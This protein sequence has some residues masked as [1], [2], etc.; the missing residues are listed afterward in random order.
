[1][2]LQVPTH[3]K[4]TQWDR[5]AA[6]AATAQQV[7]DPA[8]LPESVRVAEHAIASLRPPNGEKW[9]PEAARELFAITP[10]ITYLNAGGYGVAP[11]PVMAVRQAW[12]DAAEA[13]PTDYSNSVDLFM[14]RA[15]VAVAE[16]VNADP[17]DIL[18][19]YNTTNAVNTVLKSWG[20][21]PMDR[22]LTVSIAYPA[23]ALT[24]GYVQEL[25][26]AKSVQLT[27]PL[28]ATREKIIS[29]FSEMLRTSCA[30]PT[31]AVFDHVSSAT[32]LR[33]PVEELVQLCRQ[34]GI[35][36]VID[37]AHGIGLVPLDLKKMNPDVYISNV[38]KWA[39]APRGCAFM[40]VK[41]QHHARVRPLITSHGHNHRG[42]MQAEFFWPGTTDLSPILAVPAALHFWRLV[43]RDFDRNH[44]LVVAAA[45]FLAKT[46][47]GYLLAGE[48]QM[49]A[50][51]A[52]I[53]LPRV[54][55]EIV[56]RVP[57][58]AVREQV[59]PG[60]PVPALDGATPADA[61]YATDAPEIEDLTPV[62]LA[63]AL[64]DQVRA[65]YGVDA[66]FTTVQDKV[67]VRIA[68]QVFNGPEDYVQLA[69]A[70]RA[71]ILDDDEVPKEDV[72]AFYAAV[73]EG[74]T[75]ALKARM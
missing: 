43:V 71:A 60:V 66:I 49:L 26:S 15:A 28:P 16:F 52:L 36:T 37:G 65:Q 33:L 21:G 30:Q 7:A 41:R 57:A 42:G 27:I 8:A 48:D 17:Q 38:H 34:N 59:K 67:A 69:R 61:T 25:T 58:T 2:V 75:A 39:F 9:T 4:R 24:I 63:G 35:W 51:M 10:G 31:M 12:L 64:H 68:A 72:D 56:R 74:E 23:V 73:E 19:A 70:L 11:K 6:T 22:I 29:A 45:H 55:P 18:F 40:Y 5:I 44:R 46:V 62:V 54:T 53:V 14:A 50:A 47:D 13:E 32:A 1:M 20:L 3:R